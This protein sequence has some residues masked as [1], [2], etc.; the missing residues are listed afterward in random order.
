MISYIFSEN[1]AKT[2]LRIYSVVKFSNIY[3]CLDN[4][5]SHFDRRLEFLLFYYLF[6][7]SSRYRDQS[8]L[9]TT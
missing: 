6:L 9:V 5:I 8:L 3:A 7:G 1:H 4:R 2:L